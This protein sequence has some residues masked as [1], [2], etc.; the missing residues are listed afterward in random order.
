[1]GDFGAGSHDMSLD[2]LGSAISSGSWSAKILQ[3]SIENFKLINLHD[4]DVQS[5]MLA[6]LIV[7]E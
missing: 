4:G 3:N 2:D 5:F 6:T 7:N 1:M